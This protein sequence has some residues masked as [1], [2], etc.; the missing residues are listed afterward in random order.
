MSSLL[1]EPREIWVPIKASRSDT[2]SVIS[3]MAATWARVELTAD[4]K[5]F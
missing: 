4:F 2:V 3:V 5:S 1:V